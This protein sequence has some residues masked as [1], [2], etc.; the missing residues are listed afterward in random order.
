M[1]LK[2]VVMRLVVQITFRLVKLRWPCD[3]HYI[4]LL[5]GCHNQFFSIMLRHAI[6]FLDLHESLSYFNL[7]EFGLEFVKNGV[8]VRNLLMGLS[9]YLFFCLRH[10]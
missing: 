2:S 1:P 9:C 3:I 4:L 7:T 10:F 6:H 8:I 5:I